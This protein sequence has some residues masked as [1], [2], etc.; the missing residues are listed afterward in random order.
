MLA[1]RSDDFGDERVDRL[2][3][4]DETV[5]HRLLLD[6]QLAQVN[7]R[8]A[9]HVAVLA[10]HALQQ[11]LGKLFNFRWT[12]TSKHYSNTEDNAVVLCL[13]LS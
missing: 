1:Y 13:P 8:V 3:R 7:K 10:G 12:E 11:Q 5:K 6:E 2:S 9:P 4:H